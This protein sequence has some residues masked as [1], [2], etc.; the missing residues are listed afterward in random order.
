[1]NERICRAVVVC[2]WAGL[3]V[4]ALGGL[5]GCD[6]PV[7]STPGESMT[8]WD[9]GVQDVFAFTTDYRID[10]FLQLASVFQELDELDRADPLRWLARDPHHGS[11]IYPLCRTLFMARPGGEF[12]PPMIGGAM[13]VVDCPDGQDWPLVPIALVEGVPI[14]I[15]RG[16]ILAGHPESPEDYLEYCLAECQWRDERFVQRDAAELRDI[17]QR[18]SHARIERQADRDWLA[19]QAEPYSTPLEPDAIKFDTSD[20]FMSVDWYGDEGRPFMKMAF[21]TEGRESDLLEWQQGYPSFRHIFTISPSDV[22]RLERLFSGDT[23]S[24]LGGHFDVWSVADLGQYIVSINTGGKNYHSMLG[25]GDEGRSR[26]DAINEA[27]PEGNRQAVTS[28]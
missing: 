20:F 4:V 17:V 11:N 21:A 23:F 24:L 25:F 3:G 15:V 13:Y 9:N 10:R 8:T 26:M 28:E 5:L 14:L 16:Y 22:E 19:R 18:F 12:R 6:E 2:V 1:M 7:E 27:I